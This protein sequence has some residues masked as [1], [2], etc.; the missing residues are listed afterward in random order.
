MI[1]AVVAS[2]YLLGYSVLTYRRYGLAFVVL[3]M[4]VFLPHVGFGLDRLRQ[5]TEHN[6]MPLENRNGARSFGVGFWGLLIG[7]GPWGQPCHWAHHLVP[8]L[9][10][11]QQIAL[12]RHLVRFLTPRQ[13]EQFLIAPVIGFPRLWWRI[14]REL[15]AFK[16]R[17]AAAP[18]TK[19]R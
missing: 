5:F 7:G 2:T 12:H 1:S 16:S 4:F 13:R 15:N 10:W 17:P 18:A 11:Y 14:L 9:P 3:A 19:L 6:L 8:S